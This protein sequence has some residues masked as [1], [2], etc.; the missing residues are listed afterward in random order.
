MMM[1]LS[2]AAAAAATTVISPFIHHIVDEF[3]E[4]TD[5][6]Q[7][8]AGLDLLLAGIRLQAGV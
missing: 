1:I 8:R 6:V 5:R 4:H 2:A 3:A 7:F